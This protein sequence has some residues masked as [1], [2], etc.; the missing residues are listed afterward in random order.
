M[1]VGSEPQQGESERP[2]R[3]IKNRK[4]PITTGLVL[5]LGLPLYFLS[6]QSMKPLRFEIG[7]MDYDYLD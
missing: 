5:L 3:V 4:V 2:A 1:R 7:P 6:S